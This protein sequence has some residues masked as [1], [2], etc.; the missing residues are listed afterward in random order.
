MRQ[1]SFCAMHFES[2][3]G[4][5]CQSICVRTARKAFL[6]LPNPKPE[7]LHICRVAPMFPEATI[8]KGRPVRKCGTADIFAPMMADVLRINTMDS[9][10]KALRKLAS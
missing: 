6:K 10:K 7:T 9:S 4:A 1:G 2:C 5:S 3:H 8:Q